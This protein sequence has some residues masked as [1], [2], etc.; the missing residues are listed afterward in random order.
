MVVGHTQFPCSPRSTQ[1]HL[2]NSL[3]LIRGFCPSN[4]LQLIRGQLLLK[5]YYANFLQAGYLGVWKQTETEHK[6]DNWVIWAKKRGQAA[7]HPHAGQSARRGQ[8]SYSHGS[9]SRTQKLIYTM[10]I[11]YG[12]ILTW[13]TEQAVNSSRRYMSAT[14]VR[15]VLSQE[16]VET[17][18]IWATRSRFKSYPDVGC[19][20]QL[21]CCCHYLQGSSFQ[22]ISEFLNI[23]L[24][25]CDGPKTWYRTSIP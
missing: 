16:L 24:H 19:V 4:K 20:K 13:R 5:N 15:R 23:Y 14:L 8:I 2:Q 10:G 21:S 9:E 7:G 11:L 6:S 25:A 1:Y 22:H 3:K 17:T 12:R 18:I